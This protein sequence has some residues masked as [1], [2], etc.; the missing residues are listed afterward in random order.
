MSKIIDIFKDKYLFK[1]RKPL[2]TMKIAIIGGGI[3]GLTIAAVLGKNGFSIDL[4]EEKKDVFMAAS[5][6]NQFRLHRGYHYPR[7]SETI[8]DCLSGEKKF[9]NFYPETVID[10]PHEHYYAIA[11]EGSFLNAAQCFSIWEEH[12]LEYE[13][14][15]LDILNNETIEKCVRVKESIIDPLQFKKSCLERCERYGVKIYLNKKVKYEDIKSYD[16]IVVATYAY[17]NLFFENFPEAQKNYQFELVEKIVLKLPKRFEN[18]SIVVQDGPFTCID[19][20][21]KTG[22]TLMG[23]VTHAI[24]HKNIGK[25]PEIPEKYQ[26]LVNQGIIKDPPMTKV[27]DFLNAAERFF[28]GIREEAV[29]IGSMFTTRTV[30]PY[31]EHDDARPTIVEEINDKIVS[32]FSGKIPTCVDAAEQV[33]KIAERKNREK[34][35][36]VGIIGIGNWGRNLV[37]VFNKNAKVKI[38]ANKEDSTRLQFIKE[39]Y[40]TFE[41]TH[42]YEDILNDPSIEIVV[43]ATPIKTHFEIAKKALYKN[44]KV[45]LEKPL[46][47]NLI[48]AEELIKLSKGK[49]F[50]VGHLFLYHPCYKM[51][52]ELTSDDEIIDLELTWNKFGTFSE[53]IFLNL[54]SHELSIVYGLLGTSPKEIKLNE[55]RA[56]LSKSDLVSLDLKF[57]GGTN[58]KI[59]IDRTNPN[60]NKEVKIITKKGKIYYWIND[61]IFLLNNLKKDFKLIFES[62]EEPLE[63]EIRAFLRCVKRNFE[64]LENKNISLKVMEIL[65]ELKNQKKKDN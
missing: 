12:G 45:F 37:G 29:H 19:P 17:S 64:P 22:L 48:E 60:K 65:K 13:P 63:K 23:N 54:V 33:L 49:I 59:K 56:F 1:R 55:E 9:R 61:K 52:K 24:H 43:I 57:G 7:S 8:K 6:I 2:N 20:Y 16:L 28:P 44:K 32:V 40:P 15:K 42:N 39:N 46:A 34:S 30:L 51:L 4:F 50:F 47:E 35:M 18:K 11:K 3:F 25:I 58:C 10:A 5:G 26:D 31:R 41:V 14:V 38:C 62:K 53:D 27:K 36:N 21:G